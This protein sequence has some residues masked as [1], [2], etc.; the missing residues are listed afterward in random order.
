M[1]L[2]F[3]KYPKLTNHYNVGKEYVFDDLLD[4]FY[5]NTEK[6]DGSNTQ[7]AFLIIDGVI[8]DTK[9]GTRNRFIEPDANIPLAQIYSFVDTVKEAIE[10]HIDS[11]PSECTVRVFGE[12]FGS[13]IQQTKYFSTVKGTKDYRIF[14][15]FVELPT[16][17]TYVLGYSDIHNLLEGLAKNTSY[18]GNL[19]MSTGADTLGNWLE[20]AL[21]N[22][23]HYGDILCEGEVYHPVDTFKYTYGTTFPVLKRKHKEFMEV[24]RK[25]RKKKT[26]SYEVTPELKELT[27]DISS[28]V[29]E[30]RLDNILSHGDI[31]LSPKNIGVLIKAMNDDISEE[32]MQDNPE[33]N[34]NLLS[35]ALR[36]LNKDIALLIKNKLGI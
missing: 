16:D 15:V 36:R 13:K 5:Y 6:I 1:E 24:S 30:R 28:Y 25:P 4:T 32:Y 21:L 3:K 12:I 31:M 35:Q 33:T 2:Q 27:D 23:S 26:T 8:K 18:L 19:D 10:L 7:M 11:L 22:K 14:D 34:A 20:K 17:E 9:V 29:T